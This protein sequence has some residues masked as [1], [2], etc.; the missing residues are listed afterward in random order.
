MKTAYVILAYAL[1][2][3]DASCR[4]RTL[5]NHITRSVDASS[6]QGSV[7]VG[8]GLGRLVVQ[9][10]A[11]LSSLRRGRRRFTASGN[12]DSVTSKVTL[13]PARTTTIF[14]AEPIG[15]CSTAA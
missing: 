8:S 5:T 2:C 11:Y 12:A 13:S 4:E 9:R 10:A 15:C 3:R 7:T 6:D 1:R 14:L